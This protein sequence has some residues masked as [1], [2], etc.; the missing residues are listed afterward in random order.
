MTHLPKLA[1]K[2]VVPV[3]DR[4][5]AITKYDGALLQC[6]RKDAHD[7][8]T[9]SDT[10]QPRAVKHQFFGADCLVE[11]EDGEKPEARTYCELADCS[12]H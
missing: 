3:E 1:G 5:K 6:E 8:Y 7:L 4:C 12:E 9:L 11:W 2:L 10:S